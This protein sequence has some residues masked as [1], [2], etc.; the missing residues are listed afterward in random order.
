MIPIDSFGMNFNMSQPSAV[1]QTLTK[2]KNFKNEN[3]A[4]NK[5]KFVPGERSYAQVSQS[6]AQHTDAS[7]ASFQQWDGRSRNS[8]TNRRDNQIN[9]KP[10][11]SIVSDSMLR[12]L[13]KQDV[14]RESPHIKTFIKTFPGATIEHMHSY[15]E[16]TGAQMVL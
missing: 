7:K 13:R 9:R 8:Q 14:N 11:V 3:S 5:N 12:R 16:P 1:S 15:L 2:S 6:E 10:T 4:K